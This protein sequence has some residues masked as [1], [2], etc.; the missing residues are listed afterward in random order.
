M[1]TANRFI[2]REASFSHCSGTITTK[3]IVVHARN[4][5]YISV[6]CGI[7][8]PFEVRTDNLPFQR[9][10]PQA[11]HRLS[12]RIFLS[13]RLKK[14]IGLAVRRC[15]RLYAYGAV[16]K[17]CRMYFGYKRLDRPSP[18]ALLANKRNHRQAE[19]AL[20]TNYLLRQPALHLLVNHWP[21]NRLS[22]QARCNF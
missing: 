5:D 17:G 12:G 1:L 18:F 9:T 22:Q 15:R 19:S 8:S 6:D 13:Q 11:T 7:C 14:Q 21:P 20:R 4:N 16:E 3:S 10:S 2:N